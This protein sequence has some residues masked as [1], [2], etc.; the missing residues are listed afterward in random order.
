MS[1]KSFREEMPRFPQA[2]LHASSRH[3]RHSRLRV[4]QALEGLSKVTRR[5]SGQKAPELYKAHGLS[6]VALRR[7]S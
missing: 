4:S 2:S 3:S 7:L 5:L 6:L 1:K